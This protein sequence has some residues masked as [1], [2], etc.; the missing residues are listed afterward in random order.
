[1]TKEVCPKCGGSSFTKDHGH[2]TCD[3]CGAKSGARTGE[4]SDFV[5][6]EKVKPPRPPTPKRKSESK[7]NTLSFIENLMFHCIFFVV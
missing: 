5:K 4:L 7:S 3:D 2:N 1:M 6:T